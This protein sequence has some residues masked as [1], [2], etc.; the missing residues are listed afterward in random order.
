MI[1][2]LGDLLRMAMSQSARQHVTLRDELD[3]LECYLDVERMRLQQALTVRINAS[4]DLL[5]VPVPDLLLQPLA[6]NAIRHGGIAGR[7]S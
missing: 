2:R 3:F 6:E 5:S 1:V 7:R 4:D